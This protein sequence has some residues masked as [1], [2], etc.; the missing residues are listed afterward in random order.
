MLDHQTLGT[1]RTLT[2]NAYQL[3]DSN[4]QLGLSEQEMQREL[5]NQLYNRLT[6]KQVFEIINSPT[7]SHET[8]S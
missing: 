4:N 3:I 6:S 5:I 8:D 2:L 1:T 7:E